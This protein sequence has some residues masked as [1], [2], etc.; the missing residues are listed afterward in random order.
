M[1]LSQEVEAEIVEEEVEKE[2]EGINPAP[3][4]NHPRDVLITCNVCAPQVVSGYTQ[5]VLHVL[6]DI[7]PTKEQVQVNQDSLFFLP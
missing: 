4:D 1:P 3:T 7:L 2:E 6:K 5:S